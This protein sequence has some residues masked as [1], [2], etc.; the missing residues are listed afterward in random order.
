MRPIRL[1]TALMTA[2]SLAIPLFALTPPAAAHESARTENAAPPQQKMH[3]GMP[4][5][6]GMQRL[7]MPRMDPARG[8]KLYASKG[9]V[10]CHAINGVGGHDATPLDARTMGARMNPFDFAA[11]M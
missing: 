3:K 10:A 2:G 6:P 8:R 5:M 7:M 4:M 1:L 9:C 11:K